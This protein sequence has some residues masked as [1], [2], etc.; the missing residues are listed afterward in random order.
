[1]SSSLLPW[2]GDDG[3]TAWPFAVGA[4]LLA[5]TGS[6]LLR[7][8]VSSIPVI[9]GTIPRLSVTLM[10]MTDMTAFLSKAK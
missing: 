9:S 10:Y 3:Y 7:S 5:A 1:M 8:D 4:I 2:L 6:Y